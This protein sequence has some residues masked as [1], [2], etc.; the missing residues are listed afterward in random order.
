MFTL[1]ILFR[2]MLDTANLF[3][4][5]SNQ[6]KSTQINLR[7]RYAL[8]ARPTPTSY[9]ISFFTPKFAYHFYIRDGFNF[10]VFPGTKFIQYDRYMA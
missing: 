5:I 2:Y 6:H 3:V 4:L 1:V 7:N 10:T 9:V 8:I